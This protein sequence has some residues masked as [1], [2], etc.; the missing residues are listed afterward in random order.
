MDEMAAGALRF[1]GAF[2]MTETRRSVKRYLTKAA[3]PTDATVSGSQ[4]KVA[5]STTLVARSPLC[6][7]DS[8]CTFS[9]V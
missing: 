7:A 5:P 9:L 6:G 3:R 4:S 1:Q 8:K 2:V